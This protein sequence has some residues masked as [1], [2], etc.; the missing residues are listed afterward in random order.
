LKTTFERTHH[1]LILWKRELKSKI[2]LR[3]H[4][5]SAPP[6][7]AVLFAKAGQVSSN[8]SQGLKL[9]WRLH[10]RHRN[11]QL[12]LGLFRYSKVCC[13]QYALHKAG[14]TAQSARPSL[15]CTAPISP[16]QLPP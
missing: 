2:S 7:S 5:C 8:R 13:T 12:L 15:H 10:Q 1:R 14:S 16:A 3:H 6:K 9:Q 4:L 11:A